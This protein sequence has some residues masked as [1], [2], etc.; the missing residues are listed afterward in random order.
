ML[1]NMFVSKTCHL[2]VGNSKNLQFW[3]GFLIEFCYAILIKRKI[4]KNGIHYDTIV[5]CVSHIGRS[6]VN[7]GKMEKCKHDLNKQVK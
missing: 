1:K 3:H 4:V 5:D 7:G 2:S 6:Y